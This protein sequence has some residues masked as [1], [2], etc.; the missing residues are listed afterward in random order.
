MPSPD[1]V[2][3]LTAQHG[4][5]G[6]VHNTLPAIDIRKC[7]REDNQVHRYLKSIPVADSCRYLIDMGNFVV[8]VAYLEDVRI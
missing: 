4:D 1:S 2:S 8:V 5:L 3:T 7:Q 6:K